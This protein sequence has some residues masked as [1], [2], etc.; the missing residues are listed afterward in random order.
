MARL[1]SSFKTQNRT[2]QNF[3]QQFAKIPEP[4]KNTVREACV[5]FDR[6]PGHPSLRHHQLK[7]V[8]KGKHAP[9]SFSVSPTMQYRALYVI[10]NGINIWYWIGTHAEYKKYTG[11]SR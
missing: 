11:S 8:R 10:E 2:S 5:L 7:D 6:D 1:P 9:D 4:I 3:R